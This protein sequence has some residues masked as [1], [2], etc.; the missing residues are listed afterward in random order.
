M[1][2]NG[3][4]NAFFLGGGKKE[5][6][7]SGVGLLVSTSRTFI[8]SHLPKWNGRLVFEKLGCLYLGGETGIFDFTN[9]NN[10]KIVHDRRKYK[11][12]KLCWVSEGGIVFL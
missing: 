5:P 11:F 6:F 7:S 3:H 12:Q 4:T 10:L 9:G 8:S 2:E 1:Y